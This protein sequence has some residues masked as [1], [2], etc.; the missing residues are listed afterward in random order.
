[1]AVG[2]GVVASRTDTGSR[3]VNPERWQEVKRLLDAVLDREPA[4]RPGFLDASC[5]SDAGLRAEVTALLDALADA[6][7]RYDAPLMA[8]DPLLDRQLGP[9]RVLRRLGTGGMGAVYLA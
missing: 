1:M 7:S 8:S 9:Y 2:K 5:K 4:D 3:R 6:G